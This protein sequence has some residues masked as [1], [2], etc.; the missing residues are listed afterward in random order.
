M[1]KENRE[2]PRSERF[3]PERR[4]I[5]HERRPY[6]KNLYDRMREL[7]YAPEFAK[8]FSWKLD[9]L[10][11][12]R[13]DLTDEGRFWFLIKTDQELDAFALAFQ[14]MAKHRPPEQSNV[15]RYK[16]LI[17]CVHISVAAATG[18]GLD[19]LWFLKRF[20]KRSICVYNLADV[21]DIPSG[22][23]REAEHK[24][25]LS[26]LPLLRSEA[27]VFQWD[28]AIPEDPEEAR[29]AARWWK[30]GNRDLLACK[31]VGIKDLEIVVPNP[32][33]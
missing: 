26:C 9:A 16:R 18:N 17:L 5:G 1:S 24:W 6:R 3:S 32:H 19:A 31:A 10:I 14:A 13:E 30:L 7:P 12:D 25:R 2:T 28:K 20:E 33:A 22:R 21:E 27:R 15:F 8:R 23:V 4:A 29:E 11:A